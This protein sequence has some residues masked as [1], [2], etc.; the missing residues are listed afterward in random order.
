ML[1]FILFSCDSNNNHELQT[2]G[3]GTSITIDD[4]T[5]C[6]YGTDNNTTTYVT[7]TP[8][9]ET[10]PYNDISDIDLSPDVSDT[11]SYNDYFFLGQ[12]RIKK[13][14]KNRSNMI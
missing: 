10:N 4:D 5:T 1:T 8:Y 13:P 2:T 11:E 6:S 9:Y 14:V 3:D 7:T 12:H